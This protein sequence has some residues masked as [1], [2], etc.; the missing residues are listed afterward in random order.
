[1]QLSDILK[2]VS[3]RSTTSYID[4]LDTV[5]NKLKSLPSLEEVWGTNKSKTYDRMLR[6]GG[7]MT[8]KKVIQKRNDIFK[9]G[10]TLSAL[11]ETVITDRDFNVF[12]ESSNK[13]NTKTISNYIQ[14]KKI[15]GEDLNK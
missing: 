2:R 11:K 1:M 6:S 10:G 15:I 4:F 7:K 5:P 9:K 14:Y 3:K 8:T 12:I 13:Y